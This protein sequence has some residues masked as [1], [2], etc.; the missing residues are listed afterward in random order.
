MRLVVSADAG[1]TVE[2]ADDRDRRHHE[3]C[4]APEGQLAAQSP[5]IDEVIGGRGGQGHRELVL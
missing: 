2:R 5:A 1:I 4:D 3:G